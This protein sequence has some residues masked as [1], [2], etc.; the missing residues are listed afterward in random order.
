VHQLRRATAVD[1]GSRPAQSM[2]KVSTGQDAALAL[3]SVCMNCNMQQARCQRRFFDH[4]ATW[5]TARVSSANMSI[6]RSVAGSRETSEVAGSREKRSL[7]A[8]KPRSF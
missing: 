5:L 1:I 6:R 4:R 3:S 2:E 7:V 8:S